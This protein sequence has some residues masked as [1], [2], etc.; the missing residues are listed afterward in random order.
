MSKD[1]T[2]GRLIEGLKLIERSAEDKYQRLSAIRDMAES[3]KFNSEMH[4]IER[5]RE[6]YSWFGY[7]LAS[8]LGD[9]ENNIKQKQDGK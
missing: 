7:K 4:A 1:E 5:E 6:A 9:Y 3:M 8:L 2:V